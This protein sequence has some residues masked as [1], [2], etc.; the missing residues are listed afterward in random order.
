MIAEME[1]GS[2]E[3][4]FTREKGMTGRLP[5]FQS[6]DLEEYSG[7][8]TSLEWDIKINFEKMVPIQ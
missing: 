3:Q 7:Q 5:L 8:R 6:L 2:P 1:N 4:H